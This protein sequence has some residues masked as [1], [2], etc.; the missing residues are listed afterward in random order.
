MTAL[1][2]A[3]LT[4]AAQPTFYKDVLPIVQARCLQCH[5]KGDIAPMPFQTYAQ[6]R[7]WAKAIREAVVT[8]KMPPW[9]ADP[10]YGHFANDPSLTKQEIEL[11]SA[12]AAAGAP[13]G[14]R[15]NKL[16]V[17]A[18][19]EPWRIGAPDAILEMPRAIEVPAKGAIDYQYIIF[20]AGFRKDE[21]VKKV[22]VRPGARNVVHHAVVYIRSPASRWLR[23]RPVGVPFGLAG[24]ATKDDILLVYTPGNSWDAWP[25][26]MAK[27]IPAASDIVLQIHYTSVGKAVEDRTRVGLVFAREAPQKAVITLQ[28]NNDH[29]VIPPG[30]PDYRVQ[31]SGTLP[32]D[33][34]L[35]S[36]FPHMHL[37]GKAF[38]YEI[39]GENGRDDTLLK[40][41]RFDFNWQLNY[42]LAQPLPLRAGTRLL[43]AGYFDNSPN[44]PRNPDPAAE[45]RYGEQSWDEMMIGF[46]DV[47]VPANVDKQKFFIRPR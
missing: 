6:V 14:P 17:A 35:L 20:P 46:F 22:E 23:D 32:N 41:N 2:F 11:I 8:R 24:A 13:A 21:W 31:A 38:E 25:D 43:C 44:N 36:L 16:P 28:L 15:P 7:P 39:A 40:V 34:L 29:F 26:G 42:K 5:R 18:D 19:S 37:R 45:V 33:A 9:F 12:W 3:A 1:L 47:A 30:D 10:A 4:V 27:K